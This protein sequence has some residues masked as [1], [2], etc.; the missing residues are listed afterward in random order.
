[1]LGRKIKGQVPLKGAKKIT[2][3]LHLNFLR[4][5]HINMLFGLAVRQKNVSPLSPL[6]SNR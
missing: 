6:T 5:F 3:I 2:G 4:S 1:M